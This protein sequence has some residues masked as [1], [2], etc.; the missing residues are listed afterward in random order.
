[1]LLALL[2]ALQPGTAATAAAEPVTAASARLGAGLGYYFSADDYPRA[3]LREEAEG[4]IR[5]RVAVL[6][7]GRV[8]DCTI[9]A[10]SGHARLDDTSC[11]IL[12]ARV[13]YTPARPGAPV[14][15]ADLGWVRYVL[16]PDRPRAPNLVTT[17]GGHQ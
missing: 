17:S 3:A 10:S 4:I 7:N 15:G 14:A 16:P 6:P 5:F 9:T 12:R 8:G 2:L 1:M 13:R 11:R